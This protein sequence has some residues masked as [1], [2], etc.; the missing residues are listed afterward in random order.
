MKKRVWELDFLRGFAIIMM[1]FDHLMYDFA[2]VRSLFSNYSS[3]DNQFFESLRVFA[4]SYWNSDLR[5]FGHF[6][7]VTLFL[8]VSGISYTF[9]KNNLSRGLKL[10]AVAILISLVTYLLDEFLI[11]GTL[12]VFGIIHLYAASILII[13]LLRM[14]IKSEIALLIIALIIIG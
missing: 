14:F 4:I 1:V 12:I 8:V 5:F 6:F 9:S 10:G 2:V 13:Y 3:V 7:F 11:S